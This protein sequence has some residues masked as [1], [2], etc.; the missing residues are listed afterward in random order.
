MAR[1]L[2]LHADRVLLFVGVVGWFFVTKANFG[3][4]RA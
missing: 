3:A 2:C 1:G 4:F